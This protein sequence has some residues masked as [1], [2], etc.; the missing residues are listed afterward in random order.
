MVGDNCSVNQYIGRR[1]VPYI[2]RASH[3][4]ALAV[5]NFIGA[6]DEL[7]VKVHVLMKRLSTIKGHAILRRVSDLAPVMKNDTR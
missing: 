2:G 6:D 5:R 4:F 3:R 1:G 7:I